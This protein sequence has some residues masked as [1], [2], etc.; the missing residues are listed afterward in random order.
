M[1]GGPTFNLAPSQAVSQASVTTNGVTNMVRSTSSATATWTGTNKGTF[2]STTTRD[3]TLPDKSNPGLFAGANTFDHAAP[4]NSAFDYM[5]KASGT[6]NHLGID[7]SVLL[8]GDKGAASPGMGSGEIVLQEILDG[9]MRKDVGSLQINGAA[10]HKL[11]D[12]ALES[13][14]TYDL[15]FLN[16]EQI[17]LPDASFHN[18]SSRDVAT[19][20][21][22]IEDKGV[23]AAV[24]E[25]ASWALMLG[26]FGLIGSTLRS[27]KRRAVAAL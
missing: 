24:P 13:G 7:Y 3:M 15:R 26:G 19:F 8:T 27:T 10:D 6:D 2:Q 4:G 5:F 9:G 23:P 14:H 25:P 18:I 1:T 20:D 12:L 21:F 16:M 11:F 22:T 17:V